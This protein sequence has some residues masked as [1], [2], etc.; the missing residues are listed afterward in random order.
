[1]FLTTPRIPGLENLLRDAGGGVAIMRMKAGKLRLPFVIETL[2]DCGIRR[3]IIIG[4]SLLRYFLEEWILHA[5]RDQEV[6]RFLKAGEG[7]GD[8]TIFM[9]G[10]RSRSE[11]DSLHTL[12]I[13]PSM[14]NHKR[15]RAHRL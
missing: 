10:Q 5:L 1:M 2:V 11:A 12:Q 13:V 4:I 15:I 14:T 8:S 9:S 7:A 3:I 6:Y